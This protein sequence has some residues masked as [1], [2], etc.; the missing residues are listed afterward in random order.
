LF[1][2]WSSKDLPS[3]L[4]LHCLTFVVFVLHS[5]HLPCSYQNPPPKVHLHFIVSI[6]A[7][8]VLVYEL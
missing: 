8:V 1:I 6:P 3:I 7:F 4:F 5:H 2:I